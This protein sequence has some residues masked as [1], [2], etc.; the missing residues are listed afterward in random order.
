MG[1]RRWFKYNT[2]YG[3][4]MSEFRVEDRIMLVES[5][6]LLKAHVKSMTK[7]TE[8]HEARIRVVESRQGKILAL[9]SIMTAGLG[10]SATALWGKLF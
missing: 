5:H 1:W 2:I 6:T 3:V 8:D 7:T 9:V 4:I 10:S